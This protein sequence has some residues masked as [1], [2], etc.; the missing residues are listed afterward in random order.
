V[1][2]L[3]A[4]YLL[5]L[6]LMIYSVLVTYLYLRLKSKKRKRD[7]RDDDLDM[8]IQEIGTRLDRIREESRETNIDLDDEDW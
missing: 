4:A 3:T 5:I 1:Y 8:K 7:K 6:A 2:E